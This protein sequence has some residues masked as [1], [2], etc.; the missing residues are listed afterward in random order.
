MVG[1][2]TG[3]GRSSYRRWNVWN[4]MIWKEDGVNWTWQSC[5]C[6]VVSYTLNCRGLQSA[7]S[8]N[9]VPKMRAF[10]KK[11]SGGKGQY[12]LRAFVLLPYKRKCKFM[13][14]P[15]I[16]SNLLRIFWKLMKKKNYSFLLKQKRSKNHQQQHDSYLQQSGTQY[17]WLKWKVFVFSTGWQYIANCTGLFFV[18]LVCL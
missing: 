8:T 2:V 12:K 1:V 18:L 13:P 17:L 9:S 15:S 16:S 10:P 7:V 5:T 6:I 3:G 4:A 11:A 14:I